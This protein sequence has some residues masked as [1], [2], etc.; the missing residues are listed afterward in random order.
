MTKERVLKIVYIILA[1]IVVALLFIND[2]G[3][4]KYFNLKTEINELDR[5]IENT[6]GQID[7][8]NLEIDSLQNNDAKIEQIARD[9]YIMKFKDEVPVRINKQK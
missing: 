3:V 6:K 8:L 4:M 5:K 2:N 9:K 7:K 1:M